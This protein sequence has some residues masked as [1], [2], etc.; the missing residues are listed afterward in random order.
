MTCPPH[1]A[2]FQLSIFIFSSRPTADRLTWRIIFTRKT[3]FHFNSCSNCTLQSSNLTM[4]FAKKKRG[5]YKNT[6]GSC[7]YK[8][9][10]KAEVFNQPRNIIG[11]ASKIS[12]GNTITSMISNKLEDVSKSNTKYSVEEFL[13]DSKQQTLFVLK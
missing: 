1:R 2:G 5:R 10:K 13:K 4:P 9:A 12:A 6:K 8:K 11:A 7:Q 3:T